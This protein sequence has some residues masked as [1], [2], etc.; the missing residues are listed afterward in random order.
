MGY[1]PCGHERVR[2]D[3]ATKQQIKYMLKVIENYI[4]CKLYLNKNINGLEMNFLHGKYLRN[5]VN[6]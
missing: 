1:R 4:V 6:K 3:L 5:I 2:Y